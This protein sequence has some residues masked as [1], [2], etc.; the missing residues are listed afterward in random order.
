MRR[1]C[2]WLEQ[3]DD[4]ARRYKEEQGEEQGAASSDDTAATKPD[5]TES[6]ATATG[7]SNKILH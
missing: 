6:G 3:A 7:R 4:A 1:G 5:A 2:Q